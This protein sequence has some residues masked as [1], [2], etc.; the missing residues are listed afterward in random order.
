MHNKL[1]IDTPP[2]DKGQIVAQLLSHADFP[3][4]EL[5]RELG[6]TRSAFETVLDLTGA[7]GNLTWLS[8][9]PRPLHRSSNLR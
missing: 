8:A 5:R 4:D 9:L 2:R 6:V 3:L 1:F 7:D